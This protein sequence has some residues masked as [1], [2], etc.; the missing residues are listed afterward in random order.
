MTGRASFQNGA[1]QN[2]P[3]KQKRVIAAFPEP[4]KPTTHWL[5]SPAPDRHLIF[6]LSDKCFGSITAHPPAKS[7]HCCG[8]YAMGLAVVLGN[9]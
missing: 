3:G 2:Q 8:S 1:A 7:C 9:T 5:S 4:I 6:Y